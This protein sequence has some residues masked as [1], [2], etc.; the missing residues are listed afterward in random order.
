ML[1]DMMVVQI[2]LYPMATQVMNALIA[3]SALDEKLVAGELKP[4]GIAVRG[5]ISM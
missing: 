4:A 3:E 1:C 5:K 2:V